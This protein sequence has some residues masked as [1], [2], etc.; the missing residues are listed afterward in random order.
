MFYTRVIYSLSVLIVVCCTLVS[1]ANKTVTPTLS[2]SYPT[3]DSLARLYSATPVSFSDVAQGVSDDMDVLVWACHSRQ[4]PEEA[5]DPNVIAGLRRFVERGGGLFLVSFAQAYVVDL[6]LESVTPDRQDYFR[7]GYNDASRFG[8]Y[9]VVGI[10]GDVHHPLFRGM[11]PSD[12]DPN[13]FFVSGSSHINLENCFWS[14]RPI[15]QG[16]SLGSYFRRDEK[17]QIL[18]QQQ[19]QLLNLWTLR[20][21]KVL[22]YGNSL[23]LEDFWFNKHQE[24]LETF[25]RNVASFLGGK[26]NPR[27]GALKETPSRLHAD[28]YMSPPM[29]PGVQPHSLNRPLPGLPYIGHWGW[30]AQIQYQRADRQCVNKQYFKEK[31]IDEP[32]RWGANLLEFY[33]PGMNRDEGYPFIWKDDDPI[34]KPEG[35][36]YWGGNWAA[37]WDND[38]A[39]DIFQ[40]AHERDMLV[41]VFYHPDPIRYFPRD[42]PKEDRAEAY[43]RFCRF[44]SR[45]FQNPLLHGWQ[46]SHDGVGTE[47]WGDGQNGQFVSQIWPYNPGSYRYSTA[48]LP[49]T[50][51]YFHGTWMCAFG[52]TGGI[53]ACGFAEQWRYVFHPPLYLSYQADSRSMKPSTRQWGGWANYGGGSTPDWL[54]R[55]MHDFAR[56]RLYLDSGIWWL[57]EPSATMKEKDRQF[58]YGASTDPLRCAVTTTLRAT[59]RDGYRAKAYQ[60]VPDLPRQYVCDEP[61]PQDTAFIQNN[62]FRLLRLAG[63]DRG[64]LQYDPT[65]LA[66]F[67]PTGRLQPAHELSSNLLT[68]RVK[69]LHFDDTPNDPVTLSIGNVD[70]SSDE[71]KEAGG[72]ERRYE[73]TAVTAA[74]PAQIRYE[75]WPDWP[76]EI[77]VDFASPTG[78]YDLEIY[79]LPIDSVCTVEVEMD[80][81]PIGVYFTRPDGDKK[82]VLPVSLD[83]SK[84]HRLLFR[85]Q[86]ANTSSRRPDGWAGL[87][88][89]FDAVVL[90]RTDGQPVVHRSSQPVGHQ[91]ILEEVAYKDSA[92]AY[93]Q[94]RRYT[95]DSD[96]PLL[97]I[98][99]NHHAPKP[100][101]WETRL[102][103]PDYGDPTAYPTDT[104]TIWRLSS[105]H[106]SMPSLV[107]IDYSENESHDLAREGDYVVIESP[108]DVESTMNV[109]L[110]IDDG[111]YSD[112]QIKNIPQMLKA[113]E[114]TLAIGEASIVEYKNS[115][116][117]PRVEVVHIKN[118]YGGPYMVAEQNQQGERFWLTRGAQPAG[119]VDL[120]K[121][122]LQPK[123][124]VRI[125]RYGYIDGIVKPGFGCQYSLAIKDSVR[126]GSCEV[127]VVKTGP[128]MFAPRI[129]WK[130]PFDTVTVNGKDWRYFDGHLVYLPN[131][132]GRYVVQV[133]MKGQVAPSLGRTF[134]S[135]ESCTWNQVDQTL[136]LM[137]THPHWWQGPLPG[138]IP[139]TALILSKDYLPVSIEGGGSLID[140][141]RYEAYAEQLQTMKANGAALQLNPGKLKIHFQKRSD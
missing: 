26:S 98:E 104:G 20:Q 30:H 41:Q 119:D 92:G 129:D 38:T 29:F 100:V 10:K 121:L 21:G 97:K 137:T 131:K 70:G 103:L 84:H 50:G 135:V 68:A 67:R 134:L 46:R 32:F 76:H 39:R 57:G 62:Y 91:A 136:E 78:R 110:L 15:Q 102:H 141:G 56:D 107:L 7:Y 9:F 61:Y 11:T 128:F 54:V 111:L 28:T 140:W 3:R 64:I 52:R 101:V 133:Q 106:P 124:N 72:Y 89:V 139:Y 22:G 96:S 113:E 71:F 4:L 55:Q 45:E 48:L 69:G 13:A 105:K 37:G 25:L 122:Y 6:G 5:K 40:M 127:E 117:I 53:N 82:H 51:P 114:T 18:D 65:R 31:M 16:Q 17:D 116:S 79:P 74:F 14:S 87:A 34:A 138:N 120:L 109:A 86:K 2:N 83:A 99:I 1:A 47:W 125:Q 94:E 132:P 93:R 130:Q 66:H 123:A 81:R 108:K 112:T 27:I 42:M 24:N 85:V 59:G 90:R 12:E 77:E 49:K 80:G 36:T 95:V 88:H 8:G 75:C 35:P 63:Q 19:V 23:L 43:Q 115:L 118:P 44:Q 73:C 58:V 126:P 60:T 33:A